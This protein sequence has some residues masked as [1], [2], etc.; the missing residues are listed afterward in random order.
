MTT[1]FPGE[2]SEYRAARDCLLEQEVE[3]RRLTEA[4]AAAPSSL[5]R[6]NAGQQVQ[7]LVAQWLERGTHNP[8]VAGSIPAGPT[9]KV[10]V[11]GS[12]LLSE[13][14]SARG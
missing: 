2:P 5:W 9:T 7:G 12:I 8:L 6:E 14:W 13:S 4:V 1:S 10:L 11:R 3:L